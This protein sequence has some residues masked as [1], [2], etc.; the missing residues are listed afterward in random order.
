MPLNINAH[1][2]LVVDIDSAVVLAGLP[3]PE[4]KLAIS[5]TGR[6]ELAVRGELKATRI[7]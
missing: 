5:I 2:S 1:I 4:P 7:A 3:V 6:Q